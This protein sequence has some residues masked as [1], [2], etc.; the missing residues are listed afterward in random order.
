MLQ[1]TKRKT[2]KILA[3]VLNLNLNLM[4]GSKEIMVSEMTKKPETERKIMVH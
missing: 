4:A 3:K 2:R 1:E